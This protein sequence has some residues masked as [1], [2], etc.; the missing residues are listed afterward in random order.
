MEVHSSK[1]ENKMVV[2]LVRAIHEGWIKPNKPKE[3]PCF[4]LLWGG[5]SSTTESNRLLAYIPP[6]KPKLPGHGE[7]YNLSLEYIPTQEEMNSYHLMYEEDLPKFIP[8]RFSSFRSI[9]AYENAVEDSFQN[10]LDLY[11][12]ECERNL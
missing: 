10:C 5:D 12:Q 9:P 2:K 1:W 8:K 6:P 7:S 11:S 3:A 4:H